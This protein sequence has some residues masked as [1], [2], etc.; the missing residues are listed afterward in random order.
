[1]YWYVYIYIYIYIHIIRAAGG[2]ARDAGGRGREEALAVFILGRSLFIITNSCILLA[3]Y[4]Y[5][6]TRL[7]NNNGLF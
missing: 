5:L 3:L 4:T 1:M 2:M 7:L 6:I